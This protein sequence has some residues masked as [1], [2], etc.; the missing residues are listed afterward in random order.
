M[1]FLCYCARYIFLTPDLLSWK[2]LY[3][4]LPLSEC[5]F[6]V[7]LLSDYDKC[8][9][10]GISNAQSERKQW[11]TSRIGDISITTFYMINVAASQYFF[12]C[13]FVYAYKQTKI[14]P[15][16]LSLRFSVF[17]IVFTLWWNMLTEV[18]SCTEYSKK[19]NSR[20]QSQCK[21]QVTYSY[22]LIVLY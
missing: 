14:T 7:N 1:T 2:G 12:S 5:H 13:Y 15:T 10:P 4:L 3:I 19:A 16:K 18:T 6:Y 22:I 21:F 9:P 17:R 11:I 8:W 20:N